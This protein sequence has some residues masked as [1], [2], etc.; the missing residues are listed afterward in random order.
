MDGRRGGGQSQ[1][2]R[3]RIAYLSTHF[4]PSLPLQT[5][6]RMATHRCK[7]T[8]R[9]GIRDQRN[10]SRVCGQRAQSAVRRIKAYPGVR[11]KSC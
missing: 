2:P 5:T 8:A 3:Q 4:M 10:D 7:I 6:M 1:A 11:L 9:I